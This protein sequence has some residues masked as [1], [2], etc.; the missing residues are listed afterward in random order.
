VAPLSVI[1][2][3]CAYG[4]RPLRAEMKQVTSYLDPYR[5]SVTGNRVYRFL[6][7]VRVVKL[8]LI[9]EPLE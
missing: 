4:I 5:E 1:A 7:F 9:T 3:L 8:E 6:K 2:R